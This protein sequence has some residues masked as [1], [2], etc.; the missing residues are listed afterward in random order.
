MI[1]TGKNHS[2]L[3]VLNGFLT[4]KLIIDWC[5][6]LWI[7]NC[8][9]GNMIVLAVRQKRCNNWAFAAAKN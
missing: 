7:F 4:N 1:P 5:L 9:Y 8:K 6:F 3:Q 2:F